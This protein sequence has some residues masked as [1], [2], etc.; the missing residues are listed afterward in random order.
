MVKRLVG[1]VAKTESADVLDVARRAAEYLRRHGLTPIF[2]STLARKIRVKPGIPLSKLR[3]DV[4][5]TLGGD[6]TVLRTVKEIPDL[7]TPIIAVNLGRHG[8]LTEVDEPHLEDSFDK[9]FEG[10]Y[11]L[12]K[13]W[14]LSVFYQNEIIG[15]CLNEAMLIPKPVERML[16]LDV[17][18]N[19]SRIILARSDGFIIATPTGS[20]AHAFSA[21]GPVVDTSLDALSLALVAPLQPVKSIVVPATRKLRVTIAKP[22]PAAVLVNDGRVERHLGIGES[23]DFKKSNENAHFVRF[24]EQFLV[25]SLH[26]LASEREN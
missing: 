18:Q 8:Y 14:L 10:A 5:V 1:I 3:S 13:Q 19:G 9:W 4:I 21:G 2:E 25:R 24:G 17:S 6:G 11:Y 12:E 23:V 7:H 15:K 26:R 20:T 16:N 22:G